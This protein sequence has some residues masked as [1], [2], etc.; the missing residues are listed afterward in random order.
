MAITGAEVVYA[1]KKAGTWNTAVACGAGDGFRGLPISASPSNELVVDDSL[2]QLYATDATPG[3]TKLD[4]TAP[5]Y[6]RYNDKVVLAFLAAVFGTAAAP[7]LHVGGTAAYDHTLKI[8]PA[9]DG[10]FFTL[11][12]KLGGGFVD[13]IPSWKIAKV[14][15]TWETGKP[16]QFAFSGPGIDLVVDSTV[17]TL[18]TFNNVTILETANRAY[19]AQTVFLLNDQDGP[20]LAA[21]DK[22]GP[23]KAVLTLE[24]KLTGVPGSYVSAGAGRD[25]IDEP[26]NDGPFT[27]T[28]DFTFP[29]LKDNTGQ[30][31]V[32]NNKA[33]KCEIIMTGPIIE[34]A[35]PYLIKF[36][37]PHLKPSDDKHAHKQGIID[38]TR[39]YQ[40]MGASAAPLG[41]TGNTDP[42]WCYLTNK[43]NTALIA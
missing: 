22:K 12:G 21:G 33:K 35:I 9:V 36:Q 41:M 2:G 17:N 15:V 14:V 18:T 24:R 30:L 25:L 16:V 31:D 6:A 1:C 20:V 43:I 34:G 8:A 7:V 39:T 13:E 27:A 10:L 19:M 28:L 38:N 11:A 29:R 4:V 37:M 40:V 26:S 32:K 3:A 42:C 5:A 23:S